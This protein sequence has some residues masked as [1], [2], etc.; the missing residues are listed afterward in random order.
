MNL[1]TL[2]LDIILLCAGADGRR[3]QVI[4]TFRL[5]MRCGSDAFFDALDLE[6]KKILPSPYNVDI[7]STGR[8]DSITKF[9]FSRLILHEFFNKI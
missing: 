3:H 9:E 1:F 2:T 5:L 6:T 7:G 8:P 4:A